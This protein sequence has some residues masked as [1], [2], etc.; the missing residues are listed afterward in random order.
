MDLA[1]AVGG[2]ETYIPKSPRSDHYLVGIV[3][4]EA[5]KK[6]AA[7][8]GG[9]TIAIPRGVYRGLKKAAIMDATGSRRQVALALGCSTRY[10]RKI[11]NQAKA[12]SG[13]GNLAAK[14]ED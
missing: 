9:Q 6:L 11:S 4:P 7:E 3:G 14:T 10:V 1:E 13:R 12:E 8:Y 5:L 2:V